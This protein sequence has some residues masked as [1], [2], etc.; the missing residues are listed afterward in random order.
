MRSCSAFIKSIPLQRS[1]VKK[2]QRCVQICGSGAEGE[3]E[4]GGYQ[5]LSP[6]SPM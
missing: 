6:A 3:S 4:E 5:P 1:V 2:P